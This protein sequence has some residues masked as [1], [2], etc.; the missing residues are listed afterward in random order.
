MIIVSACLAGYRCRYDG[1]TKPDPE[2][3]ELVKRGEAIPVCPELFG[4]LPCPRIP[5]S[6][7]RTGPASLPETVM[8]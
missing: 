6:G 4:G 8:M 3:V 5:W 1:K 2:I 7:L